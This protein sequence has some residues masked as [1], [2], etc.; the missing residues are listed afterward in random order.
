MPSCEC[1]ST[2][3][4]RGPFD[5]DEEGAQLTSG[6]KKHREP[7]DPLEYWTLVGCIVVLVLLGG[8]FAGLTIGLMS[9][10]ETNLSILKRSGSPTERMYAERIE[11]IRKDAHLL[12]V[13]LLLANTVVNETLPVLFDAVN[14]EGYRAVLCSTLLDYILGH[15]DGM[16]YRKAQLKE[17]IAMHDEGNQGPL[18][19]EE[20]T[21]LR[22]VLET[23]EKTVGAIMTKLDDVLMLPLDAKLDRAT[24]SMLLEA[25]HS[26]VPV[27]N[28]IRE[29]VI[30]VVLV[31]QLVLLDPDDATPLSELKIGRLPKIRVDT[32]LFEILH[33][34][35]TGKSHMAIVVE[36]IPIEETLVESAITQSP[37]WVATGPDSTLRRFRPIGVVTLEDVIEEMIGQEIVDETDV[38]V[39]VGAKVKVA[40]AFHE[41]ERRLVTMANGNGASTGAAP[42]TLFADP[43]PLPPP[44]PSDSQGLTPKALGPSSILFARQPLRQAS[45][46]VALPNRSPSLVRSQTLM[47][48]AE[49]DGGTESS[50]LLAASPSSHALSTPHL[51]PALQ[52]Y[53]STA[54]ASASAA[55][56]STAPRARSS[57]LKAS[58]LPAAQL[59][60]EASRP[61]RLLPVPSPLSSSSSVAVLLSPV[62]LG[63][64]PHQRTQPQQPDRTGRAASVRV[65]HPHVLEDLP[66]QPPDD[67]RLGEAALPSGPDDN[68]APAR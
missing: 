33:V 60:E 62:G 49:N 5:F 24:I 66:E 40:R 7:M 44:L 38:Y 45:L 10:D 61:V 22:A 41:F 28:E 26:R 20:V 12:L 36:E 53:G 19:N 65:H 37:L 55:A 64:G 54:S 17:L 39:D 50:P 11:P 3:S 57:R 32:P 2:A 43:Q 48:A 59:A 30:G 21:I 56:S 42:A 16:I 27:F 46:P 13:T 18:T 31:K 29:N 6:G 14:F 15:K 23:R 9:I 4:I 68:N 47:N 1:S 34:F 58:L 25:G 51:T 35:E 63:I 8:M 52:D 67:L